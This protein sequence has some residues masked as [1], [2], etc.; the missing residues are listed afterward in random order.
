MR[1]EGGGAGSHCLQLLLLPP[2]PSP[3]LGL[4]HPGVCLTPDQTPESIS[5]TTH[6]GGRLQTEADGLS[7]SGLNRQ[8]PIVTDGLFTRHRSTLRACCALVLPW[9]RSAEQVPSTPAEGVRAAVGST[10]RQQEP[11]SQPPH[12]SRAAGLLVHFVY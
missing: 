2:S 11:N 12:S 8:L 5:S 3:S 10:V 4:G 6:T 1:L 7:P 9:V